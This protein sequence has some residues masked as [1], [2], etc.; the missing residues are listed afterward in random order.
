MSSGGE[1]FPPAG[2]LLNQC[3][4]GDN[5]IGYLLPLFLNIFKEIRFA[6]VWRATTFSVA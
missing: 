1:S 5:E 6:I 2:C 3:Y 4:C